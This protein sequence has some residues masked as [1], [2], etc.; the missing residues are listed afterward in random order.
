MSYRNKTYVAFA[1]EDI[2][3]YRLM[4]AWKASDNIDFDFTDAHD[5]YE[6]RDTSTPETIK[7]R[8]RERLNNTKQVILLGSAD[9]RRKGGNGTS[10]LAYEV[11]AIISLGLP[12]VIANLDSARGH[13]SG[14][15]PTPFA[16]ADYY[17]MSVSFGPKIIKYALDDYAVNFAGSSNTGPYRYKESVY[18]SLGL[19]K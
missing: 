8:L 12:V 18:E 19:N 7:R 10:F 2:H 1:S 11:S 13:V 16:D 5:I 17:T 14:N 4:T 15:V 3:N 6:A 9:A